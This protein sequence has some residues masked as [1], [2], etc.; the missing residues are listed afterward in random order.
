MRK[1]YALIIPLAAFSIFHARS[2]VYRIVETNKTEKQRRIHRTC[3]QRRYKY[4]ESIYYQEEKRR[5]GLLA[6]STFALAA[7]GVLGGLLSYYVT[8]VLDWLPKQTFL[9]CITQPWTLTY[10]AF[11][12][13]GTLCLV[14]AILF[15]VRSF[16]NYTYRYVAAPLQLLAYRNQL[17]EHHGD[18]EIAED[19]F[20]AYLTTEYAEA[21]DQTDRNTVTKRKY[22]YWCSGFCIAALAS[23]FLAFVPFLVHK[24]MF[25][26]EPSEIRLRDAH[27]TIHDDAGSLHHMTILLDPLPPFSDSTILKLEN[28]KTPTTSDRPP[29]EGDRR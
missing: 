28:G 8:D 18:A 25:P 9:S 20:Q 4:F 1:R 7:I 12:I 26:K 14:I 5:D 17:A 21:A 11:V 2:F 10:L 6:Q 15:F 27:V 23:L 19:E 29:A 13:V 3:N 24:A 16:F 22:L